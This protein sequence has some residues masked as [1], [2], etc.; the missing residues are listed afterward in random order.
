[1]GKTPELEAC[2]K[3]GSPAASLGTPE[4]KGLISK[5]SGRARC[6]CALLSALNTQSER[7]SAQELAMVVE[8]EGGL[9]NCT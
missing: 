2:L 7:Q 8:A 3:K 9:K 6:G 5:T 1:M 4:D